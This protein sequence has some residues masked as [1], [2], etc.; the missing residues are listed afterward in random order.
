MAKD[1]AGHDRRAIMTTQRERLI[2]VIEV[3]GRVC[4]L[5]WS[6]DGTRLAVGTFGD[7][8]DV[9]VLTAE[10]RPLWCATFP[11]GSIQGLAWSTDGR[12]VAAGGHLGPVV[13]LEAMAGTVLRRYE[14]TRHV[15][16]L[17]WSPDSSRIAAAGFLSG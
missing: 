6:P 15:S 10:G 9:Q 7:D 3:G 14:G 13:L 12:A 2:R 16:G 4:Q 1:T 17:A 11:G 5:S 8:G